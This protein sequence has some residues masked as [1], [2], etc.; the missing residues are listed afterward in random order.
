MDVRAVERFSTLERRERGRP[1]GALFIFD[2]NL[3]PLKQQG[4]AHSNY[5]FV[6]L[7]SNW[8]IYCIMVITFCMI[9]RDNLRFIEIP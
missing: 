7:Q 8:L 1:E 2:N 9:S 3:L 5:T 4:D 6:F